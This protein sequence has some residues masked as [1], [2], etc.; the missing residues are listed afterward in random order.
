MITIKAYQIADLIDLKQVTKSYEGHLHY[1]TSS[2]LFYVNENNRYLYILSYGLV[3]FAGYD[4]LK[5]SENIE[6]LK[7]YC[8]QPL[9]NS[10]SDEFVINEN[11]E[12]D[13]FGHNE[14]QLS[15]FN[16]EILKIIMLNVG[17]SV[18]LDYYQELSAMMLEETNRYTRMLE[19]KGRLTI[20]GNTLLKFIGRTL[21]VK[22]NIIDQLYIIDQPEETWDDEYISKI[23][24]GMRQIFDMKVRF[25]NI[26]YNLQIIK[27]NLDLFKD[28]MQHRRAN[29]LEIIIIVLILVE[30]IDLFVSKFL[31]Y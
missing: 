4:E 15:R 26:D 6:F 29:I 5:I 16:P 24:A 13:K 31:N 23:D 1:Y 22:N 25:R 9:V 3:V 18:T 21:N 2:E 27:E 30:V 7:N 14:A 17:Q 19:T 11:A 20:S 28:L 8:K 12:S 10:F